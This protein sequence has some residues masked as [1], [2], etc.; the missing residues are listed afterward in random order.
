MQPANG[1]AFQRP[2]A[3]LGRDECYAPTAGA[4]RQERSRF[5]NDRARG[6]ILPLGTPPY[7]GGHRSLTAVPRPYALAQWTDHLTGENM[8]GWSAPGCFLTLHPGLHWWHTV[9]FQSFRNVTLLDRV[10]TTLQL[11]SDGRVVIGLGA[12]DVSDDYRT[13][14]LDPSHC[15]SIPQP[16]PRWA[17]PWT[18]ETLDSVIRS[19][20][21]GCRLAVE[22]LFLERSKKPR[23]RA[24]CD[25]TGPQAV[26]HRFD[27]WLGYRAIQSTAPLKSAP[28]AHVNRTQ[29]PNHVLKRRGAGPHRFV[30]QISYW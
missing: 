12:G 11:M 28:L 6:C 19:T 1:A 18:S 25:P 16:S 26:G 2:V 21:G 27:R 13:D 5:R 14:V 7:Q 3:F 8:E 20:H 23:I 15:G 30:V 22:M 4:S 29:V 10:G 17:D 24:Q 9:L